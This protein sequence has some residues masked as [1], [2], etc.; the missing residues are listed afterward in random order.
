MD[1]WK[2]SVLLILLLVVTGG[3][4]SAEN[5]R[6]ATGAETPA[7][8]QAKDALAVL[9]HRGND[10]YSDAV[11]EGI[12]SAAEEYDIALEFM[13]ASANNVDEQ[14]TL[15][16]T[17]IK[18]R[19]R[20]ICIYP[21]DAR[22]TDTV[23]EASEAGIPVVTFGRELGR[24]VTVVS[25]AGTDQ[26]HAGFA[27]AEHLATKLDD[28]DLILL[29]DSEDDFDSQTRRNGF[30]YAAEKELAKFEIVTVSCTDD[31]VDELQTAL[32]E[33]D[34]AAAIVGFNVGTSEA[35]LSVADARQDLMICGYGV[36]PGTKVAMEKGHLE[37]TM[38]ED[39][40]LVGFS[41]IMA[42]ANHLSGEQEVAAIIATG[43]HVVTV[44]NLEDANTIRRLETNRVA[45]D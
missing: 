37:A 29:L 33:H 20:G 41:A 45:R 7:G 42:M 14:I 22:I 25:H 4:G 32:Q 17:A 24:D 11:R 38:L 9:F 21:L 16:S 3:C 39:P 5:T 40:Y 12:S 10:P 27:M 8:P 23:K 30:V 2:Y 15:L 31:P 43:E 18:E 13:E 35:A 6:Q 36:W 44:D 28:D 19:F 34:T 1:V 26:F